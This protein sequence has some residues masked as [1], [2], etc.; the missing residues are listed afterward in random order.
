MWDTKYTTAL[1]DHSTGGAAVLF[2]R[3]GFSQSERSKAQLCAPPACVVFRRPGTS[4]SSPTFILSQVP[5]LRA[6][7]ARFPV[8]PRQTAE[9]DQCMWGRCISFGRD[10]WYYFGPS[11]FSSFP[12]S[13]FFLLLQFRIVMHMSERM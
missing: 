9:G 4:P 2:L 1:G 8:E 6:D 3:N 12:P 10:R 5:A 7:I 13:A 11:S